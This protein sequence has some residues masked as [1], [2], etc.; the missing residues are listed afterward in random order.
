MAYTPTEWKSGDV[1][2]AEKLNNI[3]EG[4]QNG[5]NIFV[6]TFA[7]NSPY[8]TDKTFEELI[9][10]V[11]NDKLVLAKRDGSG[12]SGYA[13]LHYQLGNICPKGTSRYAHFIINEPAGGGGGGIMSEIIN[14]H[15][16]NNT[17]TVDITR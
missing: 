15:E 2:T 9:E 10:A 12:G 7:P 13:I 6:I 14:W 1:I 8:T 3:E 5:N 17:W 16:T 4:V 11:S